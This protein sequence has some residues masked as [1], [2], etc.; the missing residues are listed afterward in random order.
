MIESYKGYIANWRVIIT[1]S[2]MKLASHGIV[3]SMGA[4]LF[5]HYKKGSYPSYLHKDLDSLDKTNQIG[6]FQ[7]EDYILKIIHDESDSN[8]GEIILCDRAD[9]MSLIHLYNIPE[10]L[11]AGLHLLGC[12]KFPIFGIPYYDRDSEDSGYTSDTEA[13]FSSD[14]DD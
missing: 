1:D 10:I 13:E 5:L 12:N 11:I 4:M 8:N 7:T 2:Y 14:C 3:P 9:T 6:Q